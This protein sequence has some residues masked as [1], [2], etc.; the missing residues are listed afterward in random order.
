MKLACSNLLLPDS[1]SITEKALLLRDYGYD[2]ISLFVEYSKWDEEKYDEVIRLHEN[3]G[4]VPCEFVF[5]DEI[6]GN[7]M[8]PDLDLRKRARQ[9]YKEASRVSARIGAITELEYSCSPQNPLP[10]YDPYKKMSSED[11]EEFLNMFREISSPLE[12]SEGFMLLENLNRYESPYLNKVEHCC[13]IVKKANFSHAGILI[14]FFHMSIEEDNM[15]EAIKNTNLLL[16]HVH[17]GDNNRLLPGQGTIDWGKNFRALKEVGYN[18]F[19]SIECAVLGDKGRLL[20]QT[21]SF[22]KKWIK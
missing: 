1:L 4:V 11:E 6:Y 20:T 10:L 14:D 3:T 15:V 7:L 18:R 5:M 19:C 8:S 2:G 22:L 16:K 13:E 12:N 9:M 21:A 17:L